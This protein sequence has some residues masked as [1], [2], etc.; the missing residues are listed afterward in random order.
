MQFT[1][2]NNK[3]TRIIS[4]YAPH[5]SI[6][7]AS[8]GRQ[9]STFFNSTGRDVDPTDALWVEIARLGK[10]LSSWSNVTRTYDPQESHGSW[11]NSA[12]VRIYWNDM[13]HMHHK[14]TTINQF[15]LVAC[16]SPAI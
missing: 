11:E 13:A 10:S 2:K 16:L 1:G 15:Q 8:V 3:Y 14:P 12:F 6:G 5:K 7:P 9:H 4:A